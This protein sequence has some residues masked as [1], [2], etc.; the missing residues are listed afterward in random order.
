[1]KALITGA[2]TGLGREFAIQ[3]SEMG[4]DL[5]VVA[6]REDKLNELKESLKTD[7]TVIAA[8][9]SDKQ[10]CLSL[11]DKVK[12]EDIHILINNAGFGDCGCFEET[13]IT[14]EL[15]MIDLNITSLFILTKL[16]YKKFVNVNKGYI[17]NVSSI[18]GIMPGGAYMTQYYATKAYVLSLTKGL[19]QELKN[20]KS[21]VHICALCPGPVDTEFNKNANVSF[22]LKGATSQ[23][24]VKYALKKMFN[25]KL[26]IV[27]VL[28][29]KLSALAAKFMPNKMILKITSKIQKSKFSQ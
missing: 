12:D 19:Y 15:S 14:R 18:A 5:I 1:M 3:L 28:T 17:L 23:Y 22:S 13:D 24:V 27:P 21:K 11:F 2:S 8:D 9:L 26:T 7:V 16:F 29:I 10:K 20:N 6:R 25:K 4:Y